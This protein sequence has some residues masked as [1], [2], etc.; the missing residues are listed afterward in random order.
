[1][2]LYVL[3]VSGK[4]EST[5]SSRIPKK[6]KKSLIQVY[7]IDKNDKRHHDRKNHA[8]KR[9]R[10]V[11]FAIEI[12]ESEKGDT[13]QQDGDDVM[14]DTNFS[15]FGDVTTNIMSSTNKRRRGSEKALFDLF[16]Q[17]RIRKEL[18]KYKKELISP[19]EGLGYVRAVEA[20]RVVKLELM[21]STWLYDPAYASDMLV[22]T[23][24][25]FFVVSC[26]ARLYQTLTLFISR[27]HF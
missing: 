8:P 12:F 7:D 17:R 3:S 1:M 4:A 10:S 24:Y 2:P 23:R 6:K 19:L 5:L 27:V 16:S 13:F 26:F 20:L 18:N 11:E 25:Y 21:T 9:K 22:S 14:N 15:Q